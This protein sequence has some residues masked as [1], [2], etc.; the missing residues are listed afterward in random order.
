LRIRRKQEDS[1]SA[2][3]GQGRHGPDSNSDDLRI[4]T[5]TL[6]SEEYKVSDKMF[7]KIP[8]LFREM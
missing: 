3:F 6:L 2:D 8:A 1:A 5:E 4:L 7:M